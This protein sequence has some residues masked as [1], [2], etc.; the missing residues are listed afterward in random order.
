MKAFRGFLIGLL[1]TTGLIVGLHFVHAQ[2]TQ[3]GY[4][5]NT[6]WLSVSNISGGQINFVLQNTLPGSKHN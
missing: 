3:A 6:F 4:P 1:L 5:S 2:E